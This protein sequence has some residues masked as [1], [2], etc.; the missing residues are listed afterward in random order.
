MRVNTYSISY[1]FELLQIDIL[2]AK[3]GQ[4]KSEH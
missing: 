4:N 3:H 2:T 1:N